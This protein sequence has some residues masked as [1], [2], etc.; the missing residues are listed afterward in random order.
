MGLIGTCL[1]RRVRGVSG[2]QASGPPGSV[3]GQAL[4][5]STEAR[6]RMRPAAT[7][8]RRPT[9]IY[10]PSGAPS[11]PAGSRL[12]DQGRCAL[13]GCQWILAWT[14]TATPRTA[15]NASAVPPRFAGDGKDNDCDGLVDFKVDKGRPVPCREC[16]PVTFTFTADQV[17]PEVS[18]HCG[19]TASTCA[20][21]G[22]EVQ[23]SFGVNPVYYQQ[24]RFQPVDL[25]AFDADNANGRG[26]EGVVELVFCLRARLAGCHLNFWYGEFP[27]RQG[28]PLL[29]ARP[30]GARGLGPGCYVRHFRPEDARCAGF[31][32]L[33]PG[34]PT[35]CRHDPD[36][37]DSP[38]WS[39]PQSRWTSLADSCRPA[40]TSAPLFVTVEFCST[41]AAGA[42]IVK[43][44][45][46][47]PEPASAVAP[48]I[49]PRVRA[50]RRSLYARTSAHRGSRPARV[51]APRLGR[52]ASACRRF[53]AR[54]GRRH[55]TSSRPPAARRPPQAGPGLDLKFP[56]PDQST[57]TPP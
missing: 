26:G 51:C 56:L 6:S 21:V 54:R 32:M 2:T 3:D 41:D 15:A 38:F 53:V 13:T 8:M 57:C 10:L 27:K 33:P 24:C 50:A 39:C 1:G 45:K 11:P 5:C 9:A 44:V 40:L 31:L 43:S 34:L 25:S 4:P 12:R 36:S 42:V 49:A 47:L 35:E 7:P 29:S 30:N 52:R 17:H 48:L 55:R 19:A 16:K 18:G 20:A 28:F 46:Y 37:R 22:Q 23:L 14:W